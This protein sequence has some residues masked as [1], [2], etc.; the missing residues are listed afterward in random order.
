M[1]INDI[2]LRD[3]VV[4]LIVLWGVVTFVFGPIIIWIL[5][6]VVK[7][8]DVREKEINEFIGVANN[9]FN[10]LHTLTQIHDH[11]HNEHD[12]RIEK[13]EDTMQ[14]TFMIK[15]NKGK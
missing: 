11:K 12:S 5:N 14:S 2:Q 1:N 13:L 9:T 15:Y 4:A 6:R 10:A 8:S 7:R 3:L